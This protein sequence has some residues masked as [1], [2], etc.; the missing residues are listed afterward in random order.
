MSANGSPRSGAED[1]PDTEEKPQATNNA[2]ASEDISVAEGEQPLSPK[3]SDTDEA[4]ITSS[5]SAVPNYFGDITQRSA[6]SQDME[7]PEESGVVGSSSYSTFHQFAM[8][9]GETDDEANNQDSDDPVGEE[10][11]AEEEKKEY[12]DKESELVVLD[13]DH[14]LMGRFQTALKTYLTKQ[15]KSLDLEL[16]EMTESMKNNKKEREDLGMFLYGVQQELARLQMGLEKQHDKHSHVSVQRRQKEDELETIRNLYKKTHQITDTERKKVSSMQTEVENLALR[17]FYMEN[18]NRDVRSDINV[19]KRA[20]QKA[21]M[22]RLQAEV[23]KKKQDIFVDRLTCE[24]DRLREQ[25]AL[26]EAQVSAQREDT[27]AARETVAEACMEIEAIAVEKK[28]L[29]Q[30]WNSSLIGMT[31][32]DEAYAAIQEAFSLAQQELLSIDAEIEGCKKTITKEEERNEQLMLNRAESDAAMSKK[33]VAQSLT[34]QEALRLEFSTYARTLQETEQAI[35]RVAVER[36]GYVNEITAM[37]KKIE[38]ESQ[39]KVNLEAQILAKLQEKMTSD[40]AAKYSSLLAAKL[41]KQTLELEINCSKVENETAQISLEINHS[42]S[43]MKALQKTLVDLDKNIEDTNDLISQS[44]NE[45]TKRTLAIERKQATINLFSKQIEATIAQ[46][47]GKEVGP[48]EI[49][50]TALTKQ[51]DECNS[52]IMSLQQYWLRLQTEMVNLTKQREEQDASVEMLRRELTILQQKKIRTENEIEQEKNEQK[53][54][55]H[56]MRNLKNDMVRLNMLLSKNSSTKEQLQ[57]N[58]QLMESE[59]MRSLREAERESIEMQENLRNLQEEKE[60]ILHSLVETDPRSGAEDV[61]D[62]EEKP[63]ATNNA[64]A[65]EDISV[66]EGEQPLSPKASDT[67]EAMITSSHSAV[68][69]Y[70]GDITQRSA[71]SQDME[72]LEESGETGVVGSSSYSTFHQFAM[73]M[74]ET[75]DEANNQDSDDPVGEEETAEEEEEKKEYDDKESELVVLDPDHPL[76]G[77]FQTALKTYL[78][79]QIKSLDLELRE[80]TE[81]MKNNKKERED[82][83]MFLYGVQQEL[84]RLQ[85]GLEK[86]HDKHSHVSVQRRQ[87]EDELETI[88]NLYK[89]THQITDTE[90]KKVSSMQTEVENLALRLFYMENM[91]RDVRSDINVMKRAVQKAEMERLQAEVEK[92]KQIS[93]NGHKMHLLILAWNSH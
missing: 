30:Q 9:M 76:M 26:Y 59:F 82:L 85:M 66:A 43:R 58:N 83:G 10:E 3:A 55:E 84:A 69:N 51:I 16:R 64:A 2:A 86:Q 21:E 37:Q 79:K 19:M 1:V 68:P 20:V 32:R 28:Q 88:R 18:M 14:P 54:I 80:M 81:S 71:L 22:E 89:K 53:D 91:N 39:V 56:H 72:Q 5:H 67:D 75:D 60:R 42:L 15:I 62:T 27:K 44:Q 11:T 34:K 48:L 70:F 47:G 4:M 40:K 52:E 50:I 93:R 29:I 6:L 65:S 33:Q 25:I 46:T 31:R 74:G 90:R 24:V 45:I 87:K 57:Q 49:Q 92:K 35:N 13:P 23:E 12:D 36:S 73:Q 7:Q 17:L 38:K 78:T 61:P 8:Q 63:Q 77:R 41:Q